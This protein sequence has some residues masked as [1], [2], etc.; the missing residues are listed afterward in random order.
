MK[1]LM[2]P[3]LPTAS[4]GSSQTTNATVDNSAFLGNRLES[5]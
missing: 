4:V 3:E 2:R 1:L 5:T